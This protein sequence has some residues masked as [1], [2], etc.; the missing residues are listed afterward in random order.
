MSSG[1]SDIDSEVGT[2][3]QSNTKK[4]K[5]TGRISEVMKNFE[6]QLMR[7][8]GTV[9]ALVISVMKLFHQKNG[10]V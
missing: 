8:V 2:N 5:K 9:I 4:R 7:L 3:V 10:N 1:L 6:L